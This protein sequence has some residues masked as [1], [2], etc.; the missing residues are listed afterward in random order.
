MSAGVLTY[1]AGLLDRSAVVVLL[2]G[3]VAAATAAQGL[4]RRRGAPRLATAAAVASFAGV[5]AAMFFSGR[6]AE[7]SGADLGLVRNC[8]DREPL[9]W[10]VHAQLNTVLYLPLA[11]CLTWALGRPWRAGAAVAVLVVALELAQAVLNR[12]VCEAR[13]VAYN[14]A[15]AAAGVLAAAVVPRVRPA[16]GRRSPDSR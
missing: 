16:G 1:A 2:L 14:L 9:T 6:G 7:W 5:V 15:G 12:G 4:H 11:A 3:C 8:V 10:D 13:D